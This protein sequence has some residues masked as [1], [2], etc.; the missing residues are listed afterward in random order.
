MLR[1]GGMLP[2]ADEVVRRMEDA[3]MPTST[4]AL[5]RG[6][7]EYLLRQIELHGA[8]RAAAIAE[9]LGVA[10][11]T[12]RR[13][14]AELEAAG[15]LVRVRGGAIAAAA[16]PTPRAARTDIGVIVP[17]SAGHFS[18][19]VKGMGAVAPTLRVRVVLASSQY[20]HP[21]E[22]RQVERLVDLGVG[23]IVIAP[24]L[25][26]WDE[27]AL[28]EWVH[29]IPVPV[30]FLERRLQSLALAAFDSAR[31]DHARGAALAVEHLAGLGHDRVGLALFD[32]SPTAQLIREGH[33]LATLRLMLQNAPIVSLPKGED[34]DG[35]MLDDTLMRFLDECAASGTTAA[36]VHTDV[37]AA[38]LVELA[39]DRRIRVPGDLAVVAYDDDTAALA[40]VPLTAVTAPRRD[41]GRET[42]RVVTERITE[43][44]TAR[45]APRH[46]TLL[47]RLTVRSS[48]GAAP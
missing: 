28:A 1:W 40:L 6:R 48:C 4:Q 36:L 17:S 20:R 26:N 27:Q 10:Q 13:D 34:D 22:Q 35:G 45:A 29:T 31:S 30:V 37:H 23:G 24:T 38:R 33:Q 43:D 15:L 19:I 47:P 5:P 41:L 9:E 42:L 46:L 18:L 7:H 44:T 21:I 25:R 32:G 39:T 14:I 8:V 12:I 2:R 3:T 11:V 16:P